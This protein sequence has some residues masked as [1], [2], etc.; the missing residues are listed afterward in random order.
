MPDGQ[1]PSKKA[2]LWEMVASG[3]GYHLDNFGRWLIASSPKIGGA[4]AA[5]LAPGEPT[6]HTQPSWRF[7]QEYYE[8]RRWLACRRGALW[9]AAARLAISV[10]LTLRWYHGTLVDVMLGNDNSLCLYVCGSFEP[11]F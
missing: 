5:L 10:P 1:Q 2:N 7:A 9:E 8:Q 11:N 6:P 4:Y 3:V